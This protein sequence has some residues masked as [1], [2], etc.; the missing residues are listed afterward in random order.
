MVMAVSF[1][2]PEYTVNAD[3]LGTLQ[4]WKPLDYSDY[5]RLRTQA[6]IELWGWYKMPQT[7]RTPFYPRSP[8]EAKMY[9]YWITV[10]YREA[11]NMYL[12]WDIV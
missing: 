4:S 12:Q 6:Y 3:G 2:T 8:I 5:Q 1:E 7:E 11:Y 9:A 10:N